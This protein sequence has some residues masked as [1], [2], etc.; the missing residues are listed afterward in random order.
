MALDAIPTCLHRQH[1]PPRRCSECGCYLT[2]WNDTET[3]WPCEHSWT[4][5]DAIY[6]SADREYFG[7]A[8]ARYLEPTPA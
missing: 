7:E 4:P 3:C 2:S 1:P 8:L 6:T 5:E